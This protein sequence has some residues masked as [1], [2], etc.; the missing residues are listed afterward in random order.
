MQSLDS[1]GGPRQFIST[2]SRLTSS[3]ALL[4]LALNKSQRHLNSPALF[5]GKLN[6]VDF[7]HT[8]ILETIKICFTILLSTKFCLAARLRSDM[9]WISQLGCLSPS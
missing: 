1:M 4:L 7:L 5:C 6:I 2:D 9:R 3:K 8:L